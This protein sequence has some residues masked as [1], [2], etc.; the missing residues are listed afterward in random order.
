M[1]SLV[2]AGATSGSTTITPSATGTYTI[3]L[4]AETGTIQTSG[5]GFTTNGVA[6]ASSTS[7]LTTGS[8]LTFNGTNLGIGTTS[9]ASKL[10]LNTGV[11]GAFP[12][13]SGTTQ[14]AGLAARIKDT[15]NANLDIGSAGGNGSWLQVTNVTDL[16]ATYPLLLNPNGGNVGI[17]TNSP[18]GLL[19]V[20]STSVVANPTAWGAGYSVFGPNAG[21]A[22]GA[23]LG[24]SYYT[25]S[26]QAQITALAPG[27]AWKPL[28]LASGGLIFQTSNGSD[29]GRFDSSGNLLVG[30]TSQIG[31]GRISSTSTE[32][33]GS[34]RTTATAGNYSSLYLSRNGNDGHAV[35]FN[36][37][38]TTQVGTIGITST[39]TSYNT[40]SD[41]RLKNTIAPMTGALAKVAL[42]KPVTYKW[43][44]DGSDAEGFIAHELA[45]VC[46]H[47]VSGEKDGVDEDGNPRYQGIDTSFLVATL[48][49]ALQELSTLITAQQST[50]QSLTER[51]TALEGART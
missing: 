2:L 20:A 44:A 5:A 10:Q 7:A 29:A 49:S 11:G 23:A 35:E 43:N 51:I 27:V 12:A 45:E 26:D 25:A 46:P 42:L 6:Y 8:A 13:T 33:G 4:P 34:F 48:T 38:S 28:V 19:S 36:W 22:N 32:I 16:S 50:I 40:S 15:S 31:A 47:A 30:T 41:Y 37:N 21:S 24:L 3:T 18:T 39:T 1:G 9:P 17:G 14:S